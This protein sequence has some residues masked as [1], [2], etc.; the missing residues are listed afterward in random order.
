MKVGDWVY[1]KNSVQKSFFRIGWIACPL[2]LNE[3][4]KEPVYYY[5]QLIECGLGGWIIGTYN[6]PEYWKSENYVFNGVS[7]SL[8]NNYQVISK[9]DLVKTI[10]ES[11]KPY[12]GFNE[13]YGISGPPRLL[14]NQ[15]ERMGLENIVEMFK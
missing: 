12:K 1:N 2:S 13:A 3:R 7:E 5:D 15:A 4:Q 10:K 8:I 6:E 11:I 9:Y 14:L